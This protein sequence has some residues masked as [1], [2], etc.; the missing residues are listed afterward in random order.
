MKSKS[1]VK[2]GSLYIFGNLFNKAVAFITVPIFT[3]LL[4]TEE[5]GIINIYTS[6]VNLMAVIVGLSL[7]NSIRNAY[8]DMREELG[9]YI[10]SI[11]TLAVVNFAAVCV[12]V[13]LLANHISLPN[14]LI[15][16]C[17][18]ESFS[19]FIINAVVMRYVMEEEAVKRTALLVLPN[20]LGAILSVVLISMLT[21][22]KQYGRIIATCVVTS[23]FGIGLMLYYMI[24]YKTFFNKKFWMY[25]LPISIPLVFHGISCNILG[26]SDRSVI[27]YF[28]G[29]AA[30]G[31]YS[32]IYNLSM[33][34]SVVIS[35]AESVWLPRMTRSLQ[36][37]DYKTFNHEVLI[38]VYIVLF[39]FCGL[40]TFAPELILL[41]GGK[42]YLSGLTMIFPIVAS[43][44]VMFIY[45]IYVN[46]E[47]YYKKTR[48][49]AIATVVA[50]ALNLLLNFIFIP[51]FGVTA[52]AYTT[53][54]SYFISFLLHSLNAKNVDKQ[55]VPYKIL[56]A[57]V[58]IIIVAGIIT[59]MTVDKMLLRWG[60]MIVLGLIYGILC[61]K[62]LLQEK[63]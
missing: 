54:V 55:A 58:A 59:S 52:A 57:P 23:L 3:R 10:S 31:V 19:N 16:F 2:S 34:S 13:A 20:L 51:Y 35:S 37:Q 32:L 4:T 27:T 7:G 44:F 50:A 5:Y 43:S 12:V 48:M 40:L 28:C 47:Y 45:S 18:M 56:I 42:E 33:V 1:V 41:L 6:W 46:I 25:A 26:T 9:E 15:W 17:L 61:W 62:I 29:A 30:A 36:K 22:N 39:A 14:E 53:L 11:F 63:E 38:Y 24:R 60:I 8:V 21:Q 49:I